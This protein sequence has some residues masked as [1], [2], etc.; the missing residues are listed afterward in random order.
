[1]IYNPGLKTESIH[2]HMTKDVQS[3][4]EETQLSDVANLFI[5]HRIRRVPVTRAGKVV[6][7]ISRPELI[8]YALEAGHDSDT[9]ELA[10]SIHAS[11]K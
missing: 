7:I 9:A 11:V 5:V 8:R 3:V 6:G 10:V 2:E 1:M 4:T